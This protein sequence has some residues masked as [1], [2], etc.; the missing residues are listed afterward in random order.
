MTVDERIEERL[1]TVPQRPGV[2]IH[3]DKEGTPLYVGKAAVL[4]NRLRS[5]FGRSR[6]TSHKILKLVSR[7]ADF[8]YIVTDTEQEALL[9]ENTLIKKYKPR[10]NAR[11]KDDKTYPFIKIDFSEEF[12]RVY[13]T[14]RAS[15]GRKARYF[16]PFAS[17]GSMRQTLRLLDRLFP[18]R[19]CTKNITGKDE[20]PCIQYHINRCIAPCTGYASKEEYMAVIEQVVKFLE[21]NTSAVVKDLKSGMRKASDTLEFERAAILRDRLQA[22]EKISEGQK[23]AG[24]SNSA[25]MDAVGIF[26]RSNEA[27]AE[28][29]FIRHGTVAGRDSFIMEGVAEASDSQVISAFISQFYGRSP[30]VPKEIIVPVEVDSID[31]ISKWLNEK[32]GTTV[33]IRVPRRGVKK[34]LLALV[35]KN[36]K[37]RLLQLNMRR[38]TDEAATAKIMETLMEELGL[39][40]IPRRIECYD[41]SHI[42]GNYVVASM[43]VFENALPAPSQYRRFNIR[44]DPKNDDL[45]S[46]RE[47]IYRRFRRLKDSQ[48]TGEVIQSFGKKPDLVLIDGGK[49]QLGVAHEVILRLGLAEIPVVSIA[50][51]E[52]EI[53]HPENSDPIKLDRNSEALMLLQRARDEAHRFAITFHRNVRSKAAAKSALDDIS[54]IGAKRKKALLRRFGSV[55]G[56]REA[57]LEEIA[58]APGITQPLAIKLKANL[59]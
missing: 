34:E 9:L 14:R 40:H 59:G 37:E 49:G 58:S 50:K 39:P 10:Y 56:I 27:C 7:V 46:M 55:A 36:A 41:I 20:H 11:L 35:E 6:E 38:F 53:F 33:S 13:I 26:R 23:M 47:V 16:G 28:I 4:R 25:D 32:R 43:A 21:G 24:L 51:R 2:Y 45:E 52:E 17:A 15:G 29:F 12:P 57:T 3:K 31:L 1:L 18:Y 30:H 44:F 48:E 42:Q 5:Y 8:E 19:T 22:I 54:G